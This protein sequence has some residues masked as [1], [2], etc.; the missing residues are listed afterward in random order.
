MG[1]YRMFIA[2]TMTALSLQVYAQIRT[3]EQEFIPGRYEYTHSW[4]YTAP[5]GNG[6]IHCGEVGVLFF[7]ADGTFAD[8]AYQYHQLGMARPE[9]VTFEW[10]SPEPQTTDAYGFY[11]HYFCPGEWRVENGKFLFSEKAEG[12]R[13]DLLNEPKN[14]W[15]EDYAN[16]IER[17]SRPNSA[18]WI[19]F[20]IERLDNEWFIWTY[21]YP[22]GRKDSWEMKRAQP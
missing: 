1:K 22:N 5:G 4:S 9:S 18:R 10:I 19:T 17:H 7:Y 13:M 16:R 20:D 3:P 12:F 8:T 6:I 14:Q 21:T 15:I 2:A 11:F